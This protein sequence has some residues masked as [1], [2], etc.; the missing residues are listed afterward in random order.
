MKHKK[1]NNNS[2]VYRHRSNFNHDFDWKETNVLEDKKIYK[3]PNV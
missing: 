1:V 3:S 2:V